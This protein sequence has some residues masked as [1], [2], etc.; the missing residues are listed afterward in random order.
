[1][2]PENTSSNRYWYGPYEGSEARSRRRL[3]HDLGVDADAAGAMLHL[4]RQIIELQSYI[5]QL[6]TELTAHNASQQMRLARYREIYYEASWIE[7]ES[8]E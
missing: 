6:E 3:Q 7:L 8:Q 5:R 1:M 2:T 4:R